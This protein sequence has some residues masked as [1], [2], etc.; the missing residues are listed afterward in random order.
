[1]RTTEFR[2]ELRIEIWELG[3]GSWEHVGRVLLFRPGRM[4]GPRNTTRPTAIAEA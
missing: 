2:N 3:I 4:A 1:M